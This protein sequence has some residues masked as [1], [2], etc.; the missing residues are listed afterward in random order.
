MKA[1]FQT[2]F[3][4]L[5]FSLKGW[6]QNANMLNNPSFEDTPKTGEA[7]SE[8]YNCGTENET[9]PDVQPGAFGVDTWPF[10]GDTY[11]GLVVR[12]NE[13]WE[14]VGQELKNPLLKDSIYELRIFL[15]RSELYLSTSK[16]TGQ[17]ANYATPVILQVWGG[18]EYCDRQE[19]LANTPVV[20]NTNWKEF[21]LN[22]I[23]LEE[24]K[25]DYFTLEAYYKT[26]VLFAYN[27]N[28][29]LDK[30][31]LTKKGQGQK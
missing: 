4:I 31:S 11:L 1:L 7:P 23:P 18:T 22:I 8:W 3:L 6:G 10:D 30:C 24:D 19:L 16:L 28:I 25:Y 9:P 21:I 14:A 15:A 20:S 27:G 13:T 17:E 29:L 12:D 5:I 2:T 26:P